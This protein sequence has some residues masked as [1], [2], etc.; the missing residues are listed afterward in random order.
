M[1]DWPLQE[2]TPARLCARALACA[3]CL[4]G[5]AW[6]PSVASQQQ[7]EQQEDPGEQVK[8]ALVPPKLVRLQPAVY[9]REQLEQRIAGSVLLRLTLD[10][11]GGVTEVE[12]IESA[13]EAFDAA[14]R[15]SALTSEFAPATRDGEAIASRISFPVRFT[16][17]P[18]TEGEVAGTVQMPDGGRGVAG[19]LV[20]LQ[21]EDGARF[22][23]RADLDGR[24]EIEDLPEGSYALTASAPGVGEVQLEVRV[25][26]GATTA[27]VL[28][29]IAEES[30]EP[31]EV[32]VRG[33]SQA[34]R[35]RESAEAVDVIETLED[36]KRTADLGE[37]LARNKGVGVQR[38]GGLGSRVRLSLNGLEEEQIP[39]FIDGVPIELMGYSFGFANIPLSLVQ[40]VDIYRGVVPV[41]YS[42]DALGGAI[43][44]VTRS[45]PK[46]TTAGVV[47]QAGSFGTQRASADASVYIKSLG[48]YVQASGFLDRA[49][50]DFAINVEIPDESGDPDPV[51]VY[52][53]HDS[54]RADGARVA[55]GVV[56]RAWADRLEVRG[57]ATRAGGDVQHNVV[58]TIPY[59]EV[60]QDVSSLGG[61]VRYEHTF[62]SRVSLD[63]VAGRARDTRQ[64]QDT[65]RCTYNWFGRCLRERIS[66]GEIDG[67]PRDVLAVDTGTYLRAHAVVRLSERQQLRIAIGPERFVRT[68]DDLLVDETQEG[69]SDPLTAEAKVFTQ[70]T[71]VEHELDLFGDALE[72]IAFVKLYNQRVSAEEVQPGDTILRRDRTSRF[73]GLGDSA[74]LNIRD[75]LWLKASYEWATR[76]PGSLEIFGDG[77][78]TA[79]NL[80][81]RPERSHNINLGATLEAEDT[82]AGGVR[83]SVNGFFRLVEDFIVLSASGQSFSFQN[84]FGARVAG[85]EASAGWTSPGEW[86]S[87]DGNVTYQEFLNTSGEGTFGRFVGDRIPNRPFLFANG[88]ATLMAKEVASTGDDLVLTWNTR[89]VEEFFRGWESAGLQDLKQTIDLQI[90]HGVS[91]TYSVQGDP[92][93]LS[94]TGEAQN[95]TNAAVFDFFGVQRPGR[96]FFFKTTGRF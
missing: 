7:P 22:E 57:F 18:V 84:I 49:D 9:P 19:A 56:D 42:S 29:L 36:Q 47:Y 73:L 45:D 92:L 52:R 34:D 59:G 64:F 89:F 1:A 16:P 30:P 94:F 71:G 33:K 86:V 10:A 24:F 82:P 63:V 17:P 66:R 32:E 14:A 75:I 37:V 50:N 23:A 62:G 28:R 91:L 67:M 20:T 68:G 81:I 35:L 53:F 58:M 74:R 8:P 93:N 38:G 3:L 96:A 69:V 78:L 26:A 88:T 41:R 72:Q 27:P 44:I 54:Y 61:L 21:G 80:T 13:G 77:A 76:V 51:R 6:A 5:V 11:S 15:L 79:R 31:I 55:V 40:R 85:V 39:A 12:V 87:F 2:Y 48:A 95:L 43:N 70:V 25:K 4:A 65:A 90:T 60:T 46:R 83:G